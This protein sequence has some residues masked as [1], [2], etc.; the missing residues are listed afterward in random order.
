MEC[1]KW[2]NISCSR[3]WPEE[4]EEKGNRTTEIKGKTFAMT[5]DDA[6]EAGEKKVAG[7]S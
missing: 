7:R 6:M 3:G 4:A 1:R 2:K 5:V